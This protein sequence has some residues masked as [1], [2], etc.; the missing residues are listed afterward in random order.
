M[1]ADRS[2]NFS[3]PKS[4][5]VATTDSSVVAAVPGMKI[6]V[7]SYVVA[8][9]TTPPA[10]IVFNTKPTGAGSAIS[11][12]YGIVAQQTLNEATDTAGLFQTNQGEGLSVTTGAGTTAV[13]LTVT[14]V[15]TP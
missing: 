5:A 7:L 8:A 15:L 11:A 9:T 10:T 2:V 13:T 4:V 1:P 3:G 14:Y 12:T 6:R